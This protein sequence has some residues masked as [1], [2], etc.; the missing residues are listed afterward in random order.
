MPALQRIL[1]YSDAVMC[2]CGPPGVGKSSLARTVLPDHERVNQD[3]LGS[4]DKCY[5]V[6]DAALVAGRSVVIDAT[7]VNPEA[8][9]K[10]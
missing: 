5:R 6:A 8:S 3:T 7:N 2:R 4:K 1:D 10:Q 9:A